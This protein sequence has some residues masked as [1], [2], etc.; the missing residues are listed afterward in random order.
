MSMDLLCADCGTEY[1]WQGPFG[2]Q[3]LPRDEGQAALYGLD[4]LPCAAT[5]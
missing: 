5:A 2:L 4:R 1:R 3:E